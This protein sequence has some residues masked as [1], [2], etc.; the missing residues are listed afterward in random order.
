MSK[1][2]AILLAAR[3]SAQAHGYNGLNFRDLATEVG[4]K[5]ASIYHH[6]P[7]KADLGAAVAKRYWEDAAADLDRM[8]TETPDPIDA[9]REYPRI[10][11]RSLESDN[12]LC[13]GSFMSAEYDD[14]PEPVKKEVQTFADVNVAW[15]MK[16][17]VAGGVLSPGEDAQTRARAIFAAVA[18]AQ[19]MARSR[20][21]IALFDTLIHAYRT[22]GLLPAKHT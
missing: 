9:L 12:R 16:M 14:V 22:A 21:D 11:R 2:E 10:F 6:F 17:L 1:S 7:S 20:A 15:L 4:I 8:S 5:A 18:G 19:L 13:M 3:R